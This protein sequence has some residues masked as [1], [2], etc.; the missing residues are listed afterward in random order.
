[1][2]CVTGKK[3]FGSRN[4]AMGFA[5]CTAKGRRMRSYLCDKCFRWHLTSDV[6]GRIKKEKRKNR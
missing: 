6:G 4:R 3:S 2:E 5:K 1:M